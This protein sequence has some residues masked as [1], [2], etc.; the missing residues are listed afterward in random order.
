VKA[1]KSL[2]IALIDGTGGLFTYDRKQV[3]AIKNG[4]RAKI[5]KYPVSYDLPAIKRTLVKTSFGLKVLSGNEL[6]DVP[7]EFPSPALTVS[8]WAGGRACGHFLC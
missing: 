3:V 4:E 8:D 7:I 5:G 2:D 6:I 1:L